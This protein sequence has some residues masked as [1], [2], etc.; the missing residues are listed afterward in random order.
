[1]NTAAVEPGSTVAVIGLGGVGL[2]AV[3]G[4][5]T[6]NAGSIIGVDIRDDKLEASRA[7]GV[8]DTVNSSE[9]D[10]VERLREL[11]GGRG[12]DYA[13][14]TIGVPQVTADAFKALRSRGTAVAVGM[15]APTAEIT[16]PFSLLSS[17]R[18]LTGSN[19][20]SIQPMADI[21][22]IIDLFMDGRLPLDRL[23]SRR[24]R[25]EQ[26]NEAFADLLAGELLR[27]IIEF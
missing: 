7:F 2:S 12:V 16:V 3:M 18:V 21:P 9:E 27:G 20:G 26:V 13:F 22:R 25:L 1:M 4:A 24:Y 5:V 10:M 15:N 14:D 17:E 11:T 8:T 19:Y 6:V 23:I